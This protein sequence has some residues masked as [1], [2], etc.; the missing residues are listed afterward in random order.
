MEPEP[1][2]DGRAKF[3][4]GTYEELIPVITKI[5]R[6]SL[7]QQ[8]RLDVETIKSLNQI[9]V[10]DAWL[11]EWAKECGAGSLNSFLQVLLQFQGVSEGWRRAATRHLSRSSA[12]SAPSL[13]SS[14]SNAQQQ[15]KINVHLEKYSGDD[16]N[17][18]CEDWV[19]ECNGRLTRAGIKDEAA[20]RLAFEYALSGQAQV[21]WKSIVGSHPKESLDQWLVH[22][23]TNFDVDLKRRLYAR[24]FKLRPDQFESFGPFK[25]EILR[26]SGKMDKHGWAMK[27]DQLVTYVSILLPEELWSQILLWNKEPASLDEVWQIIQSAKLDGNSLS[28]ARANSAFSPAPNNKKGKKNKKQTQKEEKESQL[29][30]SKSSGPKKGFCHFHMRGKCNRA[31]CKWSHDVANCYCTFCHA[32]GHTKEGC[33]K[34]DEELG[35]KNVQFLSLLDED[36]AAVPAKGLFELNDRSHAPALAV[37]DLDT[38]CAQH[39]VSHTHMD[40]ESVHLAPTRRFVTASGNVLESRVAGDVVVHAQGNSVVLGEARYAP[41]NSSNLVSVGQ[42]DS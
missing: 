17:V 31:D 26:L 20:R 30:V 23:A 7:F 35:A 14:A 5:G 22:L 16:L 32:R 12:S 19:E 34:R 29:Q 2:E 33:V 25:D 38:A 42:L 4:F 39:L 18:F 6:S 8:V 15:T 28:V 21:S 24:F 37:A 40:P 3:P 13:P 36:P 41:G 11:E 1:S 9:K 27:P 10:T